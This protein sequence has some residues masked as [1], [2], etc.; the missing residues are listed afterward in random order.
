VSGF[1]SDD[2]RARLE[3]AFVPGERRVVHL[4]EFLHAAV[5]VPL[6]LDNDH[7]DIILTKRTELVETHKGQVSFPGGVV[8]EEDGD[9]RQTALRETRE[10]LGIEESE[11]RVVGLLDDLLTPT[12]FIITPVVGVLSALPPMLPNPIEVA[13]VFRVP[14]SRFM[15]PGVGRKELREFRGEMRE[16]WFYEEAGHVIWGATAMIIRSLLQRLKLL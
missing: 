5:L 3:I 1:R 12:G 10:E 14:I 15:A 9:V 11:I 7:A 6:V 13:E 4:P 2:I 16:V 8:E